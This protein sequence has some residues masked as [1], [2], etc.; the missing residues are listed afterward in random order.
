[1]KSTFILL[2]V[3][4]LFFACAEDTDITVPRN[5]QEYIELTSNNDLG[6]VIACAGNAAGN[7]NLT[8]VFYYPVIGATDVRYYEADS[9][10]VDPNDF[11]NY[12]RLNLPSQNVFGGKLKRFSRQNSEESWGLVTYVLDGRLHR[13]NP[14]RFK[15]RTNLTTWTNQVSIT[16]PSITEP[17]FTWTD[18]GEDNAIYF[19]A[20][21]NEDAEL[22]E[23]KF[24]SGTYTFETTFQYFD[25]SNVV[26]SIN[27]PEIPKDLIEDT[28]YKF[29]MMAVSE[30]NWVNTLVEETFVPRNLKEYLTIHN[31]KTVTTA[32]AFGASGVSDKKLTY[33]YYQPLAGATDLRYYETENAV[34][35]PTD[36]SNYRRRK[37]ADEAVF[38]GKLRRYIRTNSTERWAI[39]TYIIGDTFYKSD[40]VRI[41]NIEKPTEWISGET[42]K[43]T[44]DFSASL[45]PKF[46]WT[47]G[48]IEENET[49]LQIFTTNDNNFLSGTFTTSKTVQYR[50]FDGLVTLNTETPPE[51]VLAETYKFALLG[52][53]SDN[54]VNLFIQKS[55][56]AE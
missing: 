13:S 29:T 1:M 9:L 23:D 7:Q 34:V 16:Y 11:T 42:E 14:I 54:W 33:L 48:K 56:E 30:D 3:S 43:L 53:S 25:D 39:A 50:N 47:D 40:P 20:I 19:Q 27:V 22:D 37:I 26:L 8:F 17:K 44:I 38:G 55:F 6:E 46:T 49:Y 10:N 51:L 45:Q 15:N 52:L 5:L 32:L 4:V 21:S 41:K 31:D 24:I 2:L 35:D 18:F 28:A 36:F 12:R